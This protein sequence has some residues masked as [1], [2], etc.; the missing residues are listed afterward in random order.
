MVL[1]VNISLIQNRE[2]GLSTRE[3]LNEVIEIL[4]NLEDFAPPGPPGPPG[5][6]GPPGPDVRVT[7]NVIG[8]SET[9]AGLPQTANTGDAWL[10]TG[11]P[12][13]SDGEDNVE[14]YIWS[15]D[16]W[17]LAFLFTTP[18]DEQV[19]NV[20]YVAKNGNDGNQGRAFGDAVLTIQRGIDIAGA[21]GPNT[22]ISVYPGIYVEEGNLEVPKDC[23]VVSVGG[24]YTTEVHASEEC[25]ENF[26]NM[27]LLNSGAYVQ[28]F[29]FR[30][31]EIDNFN[32]PSGGFA[33]AF[34]PGA[35]ILRSPY[36]RDLGQVSNY[37]PRV[38]SAPLDPN[39]E[40]FAFD[41]PN[42]VDESDFQH[43]NPLVGPG[44]GVLL[45]DRAIL[46]Y[47]SIFPSLL[48][49][50]ATPR[51]NNGIGYCAKNGAFINGIS[52][53]SVFQQC[54]F[55]AL[56]GGQVTLNNSATQFGDVSMR[57]TGFTWVMR[58]VDKPNNLIEGNQVT[59]LIEGNRGNI[60]D[61]TWSA[62]VSNNPGINTE[63]NEEDFRERIGFLLEALG[64]DFQGGSQS[65]TQAFVL[66]QFAVG[67]NNEEGGTIEYS[68]EEALEPDYVF[69][70]EFAESQIQNRI[71]SVGFAN[72][73]EYLAMLED[74]VDIVTETIQNRSTQQTPF[75][76]L[77]ESLGHQFNN[78]GAGV[79]KN[80]LPL[81][82][83]RPGQNRDVRFSI[84]QQGRGR[85][86]F[87]GADEQ[88]NQYFARGTRINGITGKIEGR[89]F[90]SAVRQIARR[91]SN[92]RGI[93]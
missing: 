75:G 62:V 21:L 85:V 4:N 67:Q 36:V 25:R 86:R 9:D 31:Q 64:F 56:N 20:V 58:P 40:G 72:E 57:A 5:E 74:L 26:R 38:V 47:R 90:D 39:P 82:L 1:P 34:A 10:V 30:N 76:S 59:D 51:S 41:D 15:D 42:Y 70:Y 6:D 80:S 13:E 16:R 88:N 22:V 24:Q 50:A 37:R 2:L 14:V 19:A 12:G 17:Q 71:T 92:A 54:S 53:I 3:K 83:S 44:G 29:T 66:G 27:F 61:N 8:F 33:V 79:N 81:N 55:F 43:P 52:S 63:E 91:L 60:I 77:V 78:A 18:F 68:F 65:V 87:S 84:L 35:R 93:I 69:A 32:D 7:L 73:A 11:P 45:A 49:F 28:G 23:G 46:D 89:P 48:S